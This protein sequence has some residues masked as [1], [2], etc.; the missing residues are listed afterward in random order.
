MGTYGNTGV[1]FKLIN[2]KFKLTLQTPALTQAL[3]IRCSTFC[4]LILF[5]SFHD[6]TLLS[7]CSRDPTAFQ[8]GSLQSRQHY[9]EVK[10]ERQKWGISSQLFHWEVMWVRTRPAFDF[11]IQRTA[12]LLCI[13]KIQCLPRH[14]EE[15]ELCV[16]VVGPQENFTTSTRQ[17]WILKRIVPAA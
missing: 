10:R 14:K 3:T 9:L 11:A 1:K 8:T 13:L 16:T 2:M 7:H 12:L 6:T 17:H 4:W 5:L 15:P